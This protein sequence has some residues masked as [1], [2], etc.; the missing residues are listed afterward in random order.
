MSNK[1]SLFLVCAV[2]SMLTAGLVQAQTEMTPSSGLKGTCS[3]GPMGGLFLPLGDLSDEA[4]GNAG[5]GFNVG[6]LFDYFVTDAFGL[7]ADVAF[8]SASNKDDSDFKFKTTN[9]G[10]HGEW[11]LPTGGKMIPYLG[12]GVGYYNH[13]L[14]AS[15]GG[16]SAS[17]TKG[18]VG[19]NGG[20]GV[21]YRAS[22]NMSVVGDLR[23]HYSKIKGE[24]VGSSEDVNWTYATVNIALLWHIKSGMGGASKM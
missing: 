13:K 2:V 10:V 22:E 1:K 8:S 20:V 15:S 19:F 12:A 23:Y 17:I 18:S 21:G 4:Q 3:L 11:L 6:G 24:D 5:L 7:G 9:F 14:E 16:V